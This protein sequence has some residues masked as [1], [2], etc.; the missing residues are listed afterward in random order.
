[1]TG[2]DQEGGCLCS[3][4]R[5]LARAPLRPVVTCHCRQCQRIHGGPAGFTAVAQ[6]GLRLVEDAGLGWY[7]SSPGVERGFC[8]SCGASLFWRRAGSGRISVT[9]GSLDP[10][11]GLRTA[12]HIHA[13]SAGDWYRI[14]DGLP[15]FAGGD[16][17]TLGS[18]DGSACS[19][20]ST[21]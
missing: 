15:Q 7:P 18:D 13:A 19:T 9:A 10:P 3:R 2:T 11:T 17:G 12:G 5:Y 16:G 6:D 4:V 8:R 20:S 21:R 1:M 14:A